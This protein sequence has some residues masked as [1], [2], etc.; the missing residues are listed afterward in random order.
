MHTVRAKAINRDRPHLIREMHLNALKALRT[1]IS[2]DGFPEFTPGDLMVRAEQLRDHYAKMEAAHSRYRQI[3]VQ[4]SNTIYENARGQYVKMLA[5]V[6]NRIKELNR[7][8]HSR[9]QPTANST[10]MSQE[11]L[12]YRVDTNR[13]PQIGK[14]NGSPADWPGF[15]DVFLAEV[16]RKNIE[17][18]MKLIYLR[19]A[20]VDKAARILGTWQ[21][22]AV[23][24]PLAWESMKHAF[25][26]EYQVVHGILNEMYK[27][28]PAERESIDDMQEIL[29]V[30]NNSRRQLLSMTTPQVLEEQMFMHYATRRM[31]PTTR[32]AW[33]QYRN[34]EKTTGLTSLDEMKQ[35]LYHKTRMH[36]QSS[37]SP[38]P[39]KSSNVKS[40][41]KGNSISHNAKPYERNRSTRDEGRPD[42]FGFGP[43]SA[44]IM[45]GCGLTHY[46]GQCM[47]FRRLTFADRLEVVKENQLCRCCLMTGHMASICKKRGCSNCPDAKYKHHYFLCSKAPKIEP[48]KREA[49][50]SPQSTK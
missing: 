28:Q 50:T 43:P 7:E 48:P 8:E 2:G 31:A 29:N 46:L 10:M 41:S 39:Q 9:T 37:A 1:E 27:V 49:T 17:P 5:K 23:N 33:E 13:R 4:S 22:T 32:D 45:T 15:R 11:Q 18:V 47:N 42:S 26:D 44:C 40:A 25:D 30:L 14:F 35:F 19:D 21:L 20:C 36:I 12:V 3:N 34:R 38:V 16:D 24:Y 6:E